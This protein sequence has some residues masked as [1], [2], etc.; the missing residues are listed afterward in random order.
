MYEELP[1]VAYPDVEGQLESL[2]DNGY[3]YLPQVIDAHE[4]A[5]LRE[6][7]DLLEPVPDS[8]DYRGDPGDR[9]RQGEGSIHIKNAFNRHRV[10]FELLERPRVIEVE[11]AALGEDCHIIGMSAWKSGPGRPD[12]HLHTD[13]APIRL[14]EDVAADPRVQ[15]PIFN[16]TAHYYLNDIT[17]ELGPTMI[18]PGSQRAGRDPEEHETDWNGV[19]QHKVI[20]KAGDVIVFRSE[21]WHRGSANT[22]GE[23]RYLVQVHYSSR[24][25]AQRIPPYLNKFAFNEELLAQ[26]TPRQLRLLGDHTVKGE[27]T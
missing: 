4:I 7:M 26:A 9:E 25:I 12:Q 5:E 2:R 16:S 18:I 24:W 19:E 17:D 21:I 10:F 1:L 11:E 20:V 8:N 13:W 27:Y 14:P 15:V 6:Q 22:S 23:T 3:A